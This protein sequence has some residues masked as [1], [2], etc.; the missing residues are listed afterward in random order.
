M[1]V[2][3]ANPGFQRSR[4]SRNAQINRAGPAAPPS[5]ASEANA[6]EY[7]KD[8][9]IRGASF[10]AHA[11]VTASKGRP[12]V[13]A[14]QSASEVRMSKPYRK[15]LLSLLLPRLG[16]DPPQ[17]TKTTAAAPAFQAVSIHPG[18]KVCATAK[19]LGD[20][21]FLARTAP[22]LPLAGC[23]LQ[24]GCQCRYVKHRDR[25]VDS[26]RLLNGGLAAQ[27]FDGRER[28]ARKGRR[29]SD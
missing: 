18:A 23:T 4:T 3:V 17:Q 21:R 28:R 13:R 5:R 1:P 19:Q 11:N 14:V 2:C 27:L 8:A 29:S 9:S 24:G 16:G 15:S 12:Y 25:R 7:T 6:Q 26:R 10:E 22:P 20:R